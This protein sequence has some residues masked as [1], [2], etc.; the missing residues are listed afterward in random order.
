MKIGVASLSMFTSPI[1]DGRRLAETSPETWISVSPYSAAL[2]RSTEIF[3]VRCCSASEDEIS[4]MFSTEAI[5]ERIRSTAS[6]SAS[7]LVPA[8]LMSIVPE[9]PTPGPPPAVIDVSP[10]SV[11]ES[12]PSWI[13]FL[14]ASP[15]ASLESETWIVV[16]F[17][18]PPKFT[19]PSA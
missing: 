14:I 2:V 11:L 16:A 6:K 15:S 17:A 1:E 13:A 5:D 8:I 12:I 7:S 9:P 10:M 19:R 3:R 18:L 4:E